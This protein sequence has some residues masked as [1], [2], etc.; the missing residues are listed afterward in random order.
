[1]EVMRKYI[2][3]LTIIFHCHLQHFII[4]IEFQIPTGRRITHEMRT[5]IELEFVS[6][7]L[8]CCST[9][10][11]LTGTHYS[12]QSR[13]NWSEWGGGGWQ[14]RQAGITYSSINH[15]STVSNN[16]T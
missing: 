6:R 4:T 9:C 15:I 13:F 1:M 5:D 16:F 10:Q 14:C 11:F 12:R 2:V 8:L 7:Q 3:L